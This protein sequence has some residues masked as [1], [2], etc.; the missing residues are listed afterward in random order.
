MVTVL[1]IFK[2]SRMYLVH[3]STYGVRLLPALRPRA[4]RVNMTVAHLT[5]V[6]LDGGTWSLTNEHISRSELLQNIFT[7][8]PTTVQLPQAVQSSAVCEWLSRA[9]PYAMSTDLLLQVL[10]VRENP[11]SRGTL[12][13]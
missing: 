6:S 11:S 9:R 12:R 5:L 13:Q 7:G 3:R 2:Q 10:K 8:V 1:A 4:P